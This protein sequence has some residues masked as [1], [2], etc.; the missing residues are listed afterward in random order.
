MENNYL[1]AQ[2]YVVVV[3]NFVK[4][5]VAK[6]ILGNVKTESANKNVHVN[7]THRVVNSPFVHHISN[8]KLC[9][10]TVIQ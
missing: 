10:N 5:Y 4:M 2:K 6:T 9:G 7:N 3:K 8:V 1:K